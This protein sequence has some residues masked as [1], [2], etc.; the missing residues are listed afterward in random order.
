MVDRLMT[1]GGETVATRIAM[2]LDPTRFE[3]VLVS[4]RPSPVTSPMPN[5][6]V[7]AS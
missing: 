1:S 7:F 3:S 5:L 4:T 6:R 2:N